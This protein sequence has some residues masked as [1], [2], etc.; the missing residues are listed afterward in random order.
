MIRK[1]RFLLPLAAVAWT[2]AQ[3]GGGDSA[4]P[5]FP[6]DAEIARPKIHAT[7]LSLTE[8]PIS[9]RGA[10]S[11]RAAPWKHVRTLNGMAQGTQ[12]GTGGYDDS[13]ALLSGFP[14]DQG[15]AAIVRQS[16]DI[17]KS[18]THEVELLLRVTDSPTSVRGYEVLLSFDGLYVQIVRWNGPFGDFEVL[19]DGSYPGFQDGDSFSATIIGNTI[20]AYVNGALVAQATDDD[21]TSGNPGMGF[22]RRD[23]G[24]NEDLTFTRYIAYEIR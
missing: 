4:E 13:Y 18:C 14:A 2:Q 20:T 7:Q 23:C 12:T 8:N 19:G 9:E 15:A 21:I 5:N 22:F 3:A 16:P 24:S 1:A 17:D 11:H 6:G 10:W